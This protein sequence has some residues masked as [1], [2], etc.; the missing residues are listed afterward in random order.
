MHSLYFPLW[1]YAHAQ[2]RAGLFAISLCVSCAR[3]HANE[4]ASSR[5]DVQG[6]AAWKKQVRHMVAQDA[7]GHADDIFDSTPFKSTPFKNL[8]TEAVKLGACM[9]AFR[10][11]VGACKPG[12]R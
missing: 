12:H 5:A 11:H 4:E 3:K 10:M 1:S 7:E 9:I 2:V 6:T 8:T